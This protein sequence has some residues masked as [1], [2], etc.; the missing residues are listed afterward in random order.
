MFEYWTRKG[1]GEKPEGLVKV[2]G[3]GRDSEYG[4]LESV[5]FD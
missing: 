1:T 3:M 5:E 4:R 2:W